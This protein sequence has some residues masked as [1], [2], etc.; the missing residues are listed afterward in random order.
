MIYCLCLLLFAVK[1]SVKGY[2]DKQDTFMLKILQRMTNF[3][4][5][6]LRFEILKEKVTEHNGT[7]ITSEGEEI[8][9]KTKK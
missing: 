5:D 4:V 2:N 9:D 1:L 8:K 3:K 7:D 6:S